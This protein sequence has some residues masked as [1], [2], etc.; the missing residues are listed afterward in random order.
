MGEARVDQGEWVRPRRTG[1]V[2]EARVDQGEWVR[3]G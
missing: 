1:R 2:G 3:P